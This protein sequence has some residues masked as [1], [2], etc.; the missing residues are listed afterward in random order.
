MNPYPA[1]VEQ[2]RIFEAMAEL[3]EF[4]VAAVAE[5]AGANPATV[6]TVLLRR[7]ELFERLGAVDSDRRGGRW[8]RYRL[9]ADAEQR[10]RAASEPD[11]PVAPIALL[12]AEALLLDEGLPVRGDQ[13]S[14]TLRR[15]RRLVD[16]AKADTATQPSDFK[17]GT[18][19]A[20]LVE[21]LL[22]LA[23]AED[24]LEWSEEW[25]AEAWADA[26][27]QFDVIV[28]ALKG[29]EDRS[30]LSAATR[31]FRDS[32]V[33]GLPRRR[34]LIQTAA[35]QHGARA[36]SASGGVSRVAQ[37]REGAV[38]AAEAAGRVVARPRFTDAEAGAA[39][40]PSSYSRSFNY[41]T[42][43]RRRASVYEDVTVDVQP[44]PA[45]HMTQGWLYEF[46]NG[47]A[48]F[49][50]EWTALKSSDWHE[51]LDPN[52]EWEQTIYRNNAN[53]VRQISQN[54]EHARAAHAF[55]SFDPAWVRI[56]ERHV[57][58]WAH[59][60]HGLGMHVFTS[61]QRD[62]PTNMI[63]TA[64]A[65]AAAHKLRLAQ[66][67][68]LYNLALSEELEDF[69]GALHREAWQQDPLWQV[70]R[71]LVEQLTGIRDWA[72]AFFATTAVFE[73]LVGELFRSGFVLPTAAPQGD[74]V[75]PTIMGAGE[76]DAQ[77]ERK[78]A[79][80]LFTMLTGDAAYGEENRDTLQSWAAT[81]APSAIAAAFSLRPLWSQP[82][83]RVVRFEDS[84]QRARER[85]AELLG[86]MGLET[87][88][89][90]DSLE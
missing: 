82:S 15:A 65:V 85:F 38:G 87:P 89:A 71:A 83:E 20:M 13:R 39:D 84:F 16:E 47:D 45:R 10:L 62:G 11:V 60:E 51:F 19:H 37:E 6:R 86:D 76:S 48:G 1:A 27:G 36:S 46:A 70:T 12:A 24:A 57:F 28:E 53:I 79:R 77:R 41:F 52:E 5:A 25:A 34:E 64:L 59:A 68:V 14:S 90:V 58:A 49:P 4:T 50:H 56:L 33:A 40:F 78:G 54:V 75:T 22:R 88:A 42:P 30:L 29:A 74:F 35:R 43:R 67:L 63:N 80:A 66:D 23:E 55:I 26:T 69:E 18:L 44:D 72:E 61:A 31:R 21:S 7:H 32:A 81:Y 8:I 73:P 9:T 3:G 17:E 2:D